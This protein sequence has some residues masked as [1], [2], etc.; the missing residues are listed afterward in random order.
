MELEK[1]KR[2]C[3][4]LIQSKY[5][6]NNNVVISNIIIRFSQRISHSSIV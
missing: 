1:K 6:V 3:N 2:I 4:V 5:M